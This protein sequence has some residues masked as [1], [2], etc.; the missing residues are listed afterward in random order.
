MKA[1]MELKS[2]VAMFLAVVI[3]SACGGG[4]AVTIADLPMYAGATELKSDNSAIAK[5]LQNNEAQAKALGQKIA[6]RHAQTR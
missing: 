1:V 4:A 2:I 3:M 6:R 5:T